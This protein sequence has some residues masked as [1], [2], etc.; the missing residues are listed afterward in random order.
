MTTVEILRIA[1]GGD[2]VG[3]LPDGMAVFVPR[4]APRDV[5]AVEITERKARFAR[6]RLVRIESAG[7][8]RVSPPCPHYQ[9]DQCGG[10]QLQ[11]LDPDGQRAA[12]SAIIGDALRRLGR[13]TVDDPPVEAAPAVWRYRTK[14]TLAVSADRRT[15]G[16]RPLHRPQEVFE[17]DD[18]LIAAEPLMECWHRVRALRHLLPDGTTHLVLRLD[19]TGRLHLG[20][21]GGMPPWDAEPLAKAAGGDISVWWQPARGAAR[22]MAGPQPGFPALAFTQTSPAL[23]ERIRAE[24]IEALAPTAGKTVWDLYGGVGDSARA[25]TVAG[26]HVWS[27]DAD[28]SAVEWAE[29]HPSPEGMSQPPRFLHA[30]VEE[31]LHRLPPPD[32]VLL[33]PPRTGGHPALFKALERLAAGGVARRVAYVSCDPAT[34]ARDLARLPTYAL[35]QLRAYDLFPQTSHVET[36]TVLEAT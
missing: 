8:T 4:S 22:V 18:C 5:L 15:V 7:P 27:V 26:A 24:A 29:S 11:H 21:Q 19:R 23:A 30:R 2:G 25:L 10:C 1:A 17:L 13:R 16:L 32:A 20:V 28:R 6:A 12:K 3:R 14:L 33:N 34:L 36:L 31:A 35:R 9:A